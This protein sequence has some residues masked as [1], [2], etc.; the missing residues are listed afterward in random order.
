MKTKLTMLVVALLLVPTVGCVWSLHPLYTQEDAVF[1]PGLV[2]VWASTEAMAIVKA[3]G[4][5]SYGITYVDTS[6]DSSG[7]YRGRL[8]RLGD[9]LFLDLVPEGDEL[10]QAESSGLLATHLFFRLTLQEDTVRVEMVEDE[11][12]ESV[13]TGQLRHEKLPDR[14]LTLLTA[15][16]SEIRAWLQQ[17]AQN[18]QLYSDTLELQRVK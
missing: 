7:K 1:E 11:L 15:S 17:H 9:T 3:A 8:V 12:L 10:R 16:S 5:K 6:E 18:P 14:Y 2:G 13:G 4:D